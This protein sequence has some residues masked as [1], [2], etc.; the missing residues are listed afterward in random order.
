MVQIPQMNGVSEGKS[1]ALSGNDMR[2]LDSMLDDA[3]CILDW[4]QQLIMHETV[5][6]L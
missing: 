4:D 2:Y 3:V 1:T 5:K 6:V